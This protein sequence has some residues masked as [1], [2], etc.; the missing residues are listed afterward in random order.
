RERPDAVGGSGVCKARG[1]RER[2]CIRHNRYS[3]GGPLSR[4]V[5]DEQYPTRLVGRTASRRSPR[6]CPGSRAGRY[7]ITRKPVHHRKHP[8]RG[9]WLDG[10]MTQP[11]EIDRKHVMNIREAGT[12]VN[13]HKTTREL[14]SARAKYRGK[15]IPEPALAVM[16]AETERL[17]ISNLAAH[18]LK[19]GDAAP[20]FILPDTHSEPLRLH[21]LLR[22]GPVI[23]VFYRGG[24][25][26]YCNLHLR[27]FQRR[28]P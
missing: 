21:S 26:P 17:A 15:I 14:D 10:T 3:D 9:W 22:D 16:D 5:A 28:L 19:A 4:G 11:T 20:D 13:S 2:D 24:W 25:C 1:S 7:S 6:H 18:A 8:E 23:V 27:G 12:V